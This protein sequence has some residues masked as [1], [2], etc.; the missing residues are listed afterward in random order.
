MLPTAAF[1][2]MNEDIE[3]AS[4]MTRAYW[5]QRGRNGFDYGGENVYTLTPLGY[6]ME[7]RRI[8]LE[9]LDAFFGKENRPLDVLDFGCGDG[10]Y[11]LH[12]VGDFPNLSFW[13]C[14]ISVSMIE[15]AERLRSR[16]KLP[17]TFARSKGAIP[18]RKC[19]DIILAVAV[20]A[21]IVDEEQLR[22]IVCDMARHLKKHGKVVLFEITG[23]HIRSGKT[24]K[25]RRPRDYVQLFE[26]C[27]F[28][29]VS[30]DF[31]SFPAY[32]AVGRF[33]FYGA[34]YLLFGGDFLRANK[35]YAYRKGSE[36]FM[37]YMAKPGGKPGK[38][39]GN[40]LLIFE[41]DF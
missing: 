7:R 17:C 25:R 8:L 37:R 19:F 22:E 4:S 5:E 38:S 27:G 12:L 3:S 10:F 2:V 41:I 33:I 14:D 34:A 9:K 11:S 13:G 39:D 23:G 24:W 1:A 30:E 20:L 31:I 15:K 36:L 28:N 29:S 35:N 21:H 6:Y 32:N 40:S 16:A 26:Q 18:F